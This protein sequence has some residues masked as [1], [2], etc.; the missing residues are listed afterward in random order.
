MQMNIPSTGKVLSIE[1][2][3]GDPVIVRSERHGA[4][5]S[6]APVAAPDAGQHISEEV[7]VV[8]GLTTDRGTSTW[9]T[10]P[11]KEKRKAREV[12]PSVLD[13]KLPFPLKTCLF[14]LSA[15]MSSARKGLPLSASGSAAL[16]VVMRIG[17]LEQVTKESSERIGVVHALDHEGVALW[18]GMEF[19]YTDVLRVVVWCRNES[20]LIVIGAGDV[21][22]SSHRVEGCNLEDVMRIINLQKQVVCAGKFINYEFDWYVGGL[23]ERVEPFVRDIEETLGKSVNRLP[24]GPY[25]LARMLGRRALL[26]GSWRLPYLLSPAGESW[27]SVLQ[28]R[29]YVKDILLFGVLSLSIFAGSL[30][31]R[32]HVESRRNAVHSE[33]Q[34]T[35]KNI[36]GYPVNIRGAYAVQAAEAELVKQQDALASFANN[37]SLSKIAGEV[38]AG[39]ANRR[40]FLQTFALSAPRVEVGMWLPET[41]RPGFMMEIFRDQGYQ[42][43]RV[44]KGDSVEG[45]TYYSIFAKRGA[46]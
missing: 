30:Y 26:P 3:A 6:W 22:W 35:L 18:S 45:G 14:S 1:L 16:A 23:D 15:V 32:Y 46:L 36:F 34:E 21:Y 39:I 9:L 11:L 17:E 10:A 41:E 40:G 24:D 44:E 8:G 25:H 19:S 29:R 4:R 43:V 42:D 20:M 5:V 33:M 2:G 13:T 28:K 7:F 38:V 37:I 27:R 31:F 12:F